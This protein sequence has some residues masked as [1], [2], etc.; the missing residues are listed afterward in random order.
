MFKIGSGRFTWM[1]V[2]WPGLS[3]EGAALENEVELQVELVTRKRLQDQLDLEKA[4][5]AEP[6]KFAAE[7]TRNW[8]GVGDI[9]GAPLTFSPENF[10]NLYDAPGF[11]S[12]FGSAYLQAWGGISGLREKN[13][14]NSPG[15]GPPVV[16]QTPAPAV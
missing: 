6:E 11:S 1:A 12:A 3:E 7:V 5:E 15:A 2:R 14:V 4:G 9:Q 16:D 8:K 13:S 10:A